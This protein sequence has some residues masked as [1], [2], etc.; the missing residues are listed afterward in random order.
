M[1]STANCGHCGKIGTKIETIEPHGAAY[2]QA[3]IC[4]Q[5]CS[6]ILGITDNY[7]VGT[8]L[9]Q[10]EAEQGKLKAQI[11]QIDHNVQQIAYALQQRR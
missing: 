5:W 11:Q 2:K 1:F 3:A 9:K 4:C 8:L 6:A 10:L 7:N